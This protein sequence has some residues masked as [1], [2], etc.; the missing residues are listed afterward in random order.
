MKSLRRKLR[1]D[2]AGHGPGKCPCAFATD[3]RWL[4]SLTSAGWRQIPINE[5]GR[6][7]ERRS[8][9][10]DPDGPGRRL[11]TPALDPHPVDADPREPGDRGARRDALAPPDPAT[12]SGRPRAVRPSAPGD[13]PP[14][15]V[16]GPPRDGE[17]RTNAHRI[18][19]PGI[20]AGPHRLSLRARHQ[21]PARHAL[22]VR[23][24]L[25]TTERQYLPA[26]GGSIC[27]RAQ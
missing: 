14:H 3:V 4:R 11:R 20:A 19:R 22:A 21:P 18:V 17:W 13:V 26:C 1:F 23:L 12:S 9:G 24:R 8:S 27:A 10:F 2:V 6:D 15:V 16:P 5:T 25:P 7:Q